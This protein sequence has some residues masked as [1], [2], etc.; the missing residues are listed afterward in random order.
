M[1]PTHQ[2][3]ANKEVSTDLFGQINRHW[4]E[5]HFARDS[6]WMTE[7]PN[8]RDTLEDKRTSRKYTYMF[9]QIW[10]EVLPFGLPLQVA[11]AYL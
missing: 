7:D 3:T 8:Q 2:E 1:L 11:Y 9:T 5:K 10:G 4:P 6:Q